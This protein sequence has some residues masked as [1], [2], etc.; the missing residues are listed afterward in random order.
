MIRQARGHG[1]GTRISKVL[2]F[3]EFVM[4]EAEVVGASNQVHACF[5]RLKAMSGMPTFARESSQPLPHGAI[6][7][8]DEGGIE[9]LASQSH[10]QQ[11]LCLLQCSP[12]ELGGH[13]HDPFLL[14][15]LDH[16][17]DTQLRP[18]L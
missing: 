18:Y 14:G 6:E 7:A 12:R 5:K 17:R 4:R 9:L 13:L 1:R 2:W 16:R 8:F 3:R 10:L 11:G 15:A